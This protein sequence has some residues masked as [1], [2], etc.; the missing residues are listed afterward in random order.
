[1]RGADRNL[2]EDLEQRLNA[3]LRDAVEEANR[4]NLPN[5]ANALD[6]MRSSTVAWR[7]NALVRLK[8]MGIYSMTPEQYNLWLDLM[9]KALA[10]HAVADAKARMQTKREQWWHVRQVQIAVIGGAISLIVL[11]ITGLYN[12]LYG[13]AHAL[14]HP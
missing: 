12:L 7:Q 9:S 3:A 1:M 10:E 2:A 13:S 14:L 4:N 8:E 11:A 6:E 5:I